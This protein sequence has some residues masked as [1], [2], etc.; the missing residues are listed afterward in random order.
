MKKTLGI[1]FLFSV[2]LILAGCSFLSPGSGYTPAPEP[3]SISI[4]QSNVELEIETFKELSATIQPSN[5]NKKLE[6]TSS[7]PAVVK[8]NQTNGTIEGISPGTATITAKTINNLT[9]SITVTVN[10]IDQ[11][12]VYNV[13]FPTATSISIDQPSSMEGFNKTITLSTKSQIETFTYTAK[14]ANGKSLSSGYFLFTSSNSVY[15][16]VVDSVGNSVVSGNYGSIKGTSTS[17]RNITLNIGET[18][19]F[20]IQQSSI[21]G[22][23]DITIY[24]PNGDAQIGS[25]TI[26]EDF[27]WYDNQIA[28]YHFTSK[29]TGRYYLQNSFT[30]IIS[31]YDSFGNKILKGNY[32]STDGT[33]RTNLH[34]SLN[35]GE[36]YR[37]V[38]QKGT[39]SG[40]NVLIINEPNKQD[41]NI[42]GKQKINDEF[43]YSEQINT[44]FYTAEE[45]KEF[46]LRFDYNLV[47]RIE[48]SFGNKVVSGNYGTIDGQSLSSKFVN[49]KAGETYKITV[50]QR[51]DKTGKYTM[52]IK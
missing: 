20:T 25:N 51:G 10:D 14:T 50:Q 33:S 52:D 24:E 26:I 11:N 2:L 18:Y 39:S 13:S 47:L 3:T 27:L 22:P 4:D 1:L 23:T 48:D 28:T 35:E 37:I 32:G 6:W 7:D 31:I 29:T 43:R 46:V 5:A 45:T 40:K 8:I 15:L 21:I 38:I 9:D 41:I 34:I 44:Y 30:V 16:K 36:N 12:L 19:T 49:F 42:D 17:K